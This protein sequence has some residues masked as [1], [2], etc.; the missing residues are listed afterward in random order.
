MA[1]RQTPP[2]VVLIPLCAAVFPS[3]LAVLMLGP[4]LLALAHEFRTS[5]A[6][7]GQLAG[8]TAL[9]WGV[10]A[11][12]AGPV[13][14]AYGR[15]RLLLTGLLLMACGLLSSVLAW[16]YGSLL[17]CRLLTGARAALIPPNAFALTTDVFP[18]DARGPAIGWLTSARGPVRRWG[19]RWSPAYWRPAGGGCRSGSWARRPWSSG[20]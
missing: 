17:A 14:H 20:S 16:N 3:V 6:V 10:N 1:P 13:A 8:A 5:V 18:P 12:L 4:L 19:C 2:T 7:V 9:T 11:P 15:R